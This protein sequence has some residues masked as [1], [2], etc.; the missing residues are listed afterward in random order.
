MSKKFSL[1]FCS[2]LEYEELVA[3]IYFEQYSIAMVTQENGI[4]NM[5]IEIFSTDKS[6]KPWKLPL[7]AFIEILQQAKTSLIKKQKFPD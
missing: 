5:E 6:I 1:E 4:D 2:D 3:D 7:D